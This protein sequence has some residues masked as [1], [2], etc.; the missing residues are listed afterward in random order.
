LIGDDG[1]AK[2]GRS[3]RGRCSFASRLRDS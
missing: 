2:L 1:L 3:S